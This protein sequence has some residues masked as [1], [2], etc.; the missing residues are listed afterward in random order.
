MASGCPQLACPIGITL[1]PILTQRKSGCEAMSF[2]KR[3]K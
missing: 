3:K 2:V 1:G